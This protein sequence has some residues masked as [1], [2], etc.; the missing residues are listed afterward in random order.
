MRGRLEIEEEL[1]SKFQTNK[2]KFY[3]TFI[4]SLGEVGKMEIPSRG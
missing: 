1:Q 4:E 2:H 3:T